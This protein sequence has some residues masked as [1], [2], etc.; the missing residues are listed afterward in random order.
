MFIHT[1]LFLCF[2]LTHRGKQ[3][4]RKIQVGANKEKEGE[5]G[6]GKC[7]NEGGRGGGGGDSTAERR[8]ERKFQKESRLPT[9]KQYE[10]HL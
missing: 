10:K 6:L 1:P 8:V 2:L 7:V 9:L 3:T 5:E 4:C